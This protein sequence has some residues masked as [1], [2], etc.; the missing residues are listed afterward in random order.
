MKTSC[1]KSIGVICPRCYKS[2]QGHS[3]FK[4]GTDRY[5]RHLR[6]YLGWCTHCNTGFEVEQFQR[7]EKWRLHRH[8]YYAT[9][10]A[11]GQSLPSSRWV[12]VEELPEPAPVV[13]GPGGEY[14]TDFQL[15]TEYLKVFMSLTYLNNVY[16]F[17][18]QL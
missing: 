6:S 1:K 13:T 12:V 18:N 4:Q 5:G 15:D 16:R 3:I 2:L 7:D 10:I 9:S 17:W 11:G 8:R 14:S